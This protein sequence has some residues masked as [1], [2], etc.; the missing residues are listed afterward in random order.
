MDEISLIKDHARALGVAVPAVDRLSVTDGPA[1]V[2]GLQWASNPRLVVLHGARLEAHTWNGVLL[3][4]GVPALAYDLP[5][6]G[7]SRYLAPDEY[8][9]SAMAGILA[10][11]IR[12]DV[13]QDFTLVGHS[14]GAMVSIALAARHQL[15]VKRL[16]LLDATPHGLGGFP[17]DPVVPIQHVG[18]LDELVDAVHAGAPGRDRQSLV[19]GV[20]RNVRKRSDGFVE[21]RWDPRFSESAQLRRAEKMAVWN[22]LASLDIPITLIRGGH[23][24]LVTNGMTEEFLRYVPQATVEVAPRSG[25]NVH[26][27]AAA[28]LADWL[29]ALPEM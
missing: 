10:H 6:H 24:Q 3:R 4:L 25:H 20:S 14:L 9:I 7:H 27:D 1:K 23:S 19:R 12:R 2:S 8:T 22:S 26:T 29:A 13:P 28:W 18:T 21:W 15:P 11:A 16:V 5:G 17:G